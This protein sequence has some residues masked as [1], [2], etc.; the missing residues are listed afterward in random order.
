MLAEKLQTITDQ[1]PAME[2]YMYDKSLWTMKKG[3]QLEPRHN[4]L[5]EHHEFWRR[6]R[7]RVEEAGMW[8]QLMQCCISTKVNGKR[9]VFVPSTGAFE[10]AERRAYKKKVQE[11][12]SK[13]KRRVKPTLT[14]DDIKKELKPMFND[15]KKL[16]KEQTCKQVAEEIMKNPKDEMAK[17]FLQQ[18]SAFYMCQE[19]KGEERY[20]DTWWTCSCGEHEHYRCASRLPCAAASLWL[21]LL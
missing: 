21:R 18:C 7:D 17:N 6:A 4:N 1:L 15:W 13:M 3:Y 11:L 14:T 16:Q 19:L 2:D 12:R 10:L 5:T 8:Y 20:G 9:T